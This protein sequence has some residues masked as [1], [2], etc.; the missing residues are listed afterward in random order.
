MWLTLVNIPA[1]L[2]LYLHQI[3]EPL[4][5]SQLITN[6]VSQLIINCNFTENKETL[7]C[8]KPLHTYIHI[9]LQ[10]L[11]YTNSLYIIAIRV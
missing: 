4:F 8:L 5:H 2:I 10:T 9:H 7:K 3:L 11:A 1:Y 6:M